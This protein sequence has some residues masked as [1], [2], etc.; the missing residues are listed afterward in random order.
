[1][2][3]TTAE[4]LAS[5][6]REWGDAGPTDLVGYLRPGLWHV[7]WKCE[8]GN[9]TTAPIAAYLSSAVVPQHLLQG[10]LTS[11]GLSRDDSD[12]TWTVTRVAVGQT[13]PAAG[14]FLADVWARRRGKVLLFDLESG[15]LLKWFHAAELPVDYDE[16]RKS[17]S[18]HLPCASYDL[19]GNEHLYESIVAGVPL[20][21]LEED[22][23]VGPVREILR[24]LAELISVTSFVKEHMGRPDLENILRR[25]LIREARERRRE[26]LRMFGFDGAVPAVISHGDL[27]SHNIMIVNGRPQIID[28]DGLGLRPFWSDALYIARRLTPRAFREGWLNSELHEVF[29]AAEI[30]PPVA[31]HE[32]ARLAELEQQAVKAHKRSLPRRFSSPST[33]RAVAAIVTEKWEAKAKLFSP[34]PAGSCE[35]D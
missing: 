31:I 26:I 22:S 25:S 8:R 7:A 34:V 9:L 19:V 20:S 17:F 24:G 21:Q 2:R 16:M 30:S 12:V 3:Q 14:H 28:M 33:R 6:T 32:W 11:A 35:E 29:E 27:K 13:E 23:R 5:A 18:A 1:M 10:L 15:L 4:E